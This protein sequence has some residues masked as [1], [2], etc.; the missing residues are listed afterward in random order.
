MGTRAWRFKGCAE[1][2]PVWSP[3]AAQPLRAT[4]RPGRRGLQRL[5]PLRG[6]R[7][8]P[9]PGTAAGRDCGGQRGLRGAP[10][11]PG[12]AASA[13][14]R[15][16]TEVGGARSASRNAFFPDLQGMVG[17]GGLPY[18]R[19]VPWRALGGL[20]TSP[21]PERAAPRGSGGQTVQGCWHRCCPPMSPIPRPWGVPK[22]WEDWRL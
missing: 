8:P 19:R 2:G 3:R 6:G 15:A 18:R 5:R 4:S 22:S 10:P 1:C 21:G 16:V 13:L 7:V 9:Q 12:R 17:E 11:N 14:E 20:G